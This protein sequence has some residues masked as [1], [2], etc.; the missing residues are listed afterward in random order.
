V[1]VIQVITRRLSYSHVFSVGT[2]RSAEQLVHEVL[3]GISKCYLD[4]LHVVRSLI[5]E[6]PKLI[7]SLDV[8]CTF[9]CFNQCS[10]KSVQDERTALHWAASSG[11]TD[12][13]RFLVD[14]KAEVDLV[15][16]SGWTPLHIA[17]GQPFQSS[18]LPL[19]V[20]S[21]RGS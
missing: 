15:D 3:P 16:N 13:V 2:Y 17:G 10:L 8:V 11:S 21:Q 4:Q 20:F 5:S 19:M 6:N 9:A 1:Y 14:K 12:I 18:I 7:N